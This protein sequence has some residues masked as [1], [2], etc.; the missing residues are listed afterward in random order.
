LYYHNILYKQ[1]D[2]KKN[3]AHEKDMKNH[4]VVFIIPNSVPEIIL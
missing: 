2:C 1:R 4:S 3:R